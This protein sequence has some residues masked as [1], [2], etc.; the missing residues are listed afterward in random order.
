MEDC[1]M[2]EVEVVKS[3]EFNKIEEVVKVSNVIISF[4]IFFILDLQSKDK[5]YIKVEVLFVNSCGMMDRIRVVLFVFMFIFLF[6]N[7]LSYI[8]FQFDKGEVNSF[9]VF[10]IDVIYLNFIMSFFLKDSY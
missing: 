3:E 5:I 9:G 6:I 10:L 7:F 8:V 4:F 1:I 2:I